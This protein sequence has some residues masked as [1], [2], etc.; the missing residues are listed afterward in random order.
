MEILIQGTIRWKASLALVTF[1]AADCP[2]ADADAWREVH[3]GPL[4]RAIN[5]STPSSQRF[6]IHLYNS[7]NFAYSLHKAHSFSLL[8]NMV[9]T[10]TY[11]FRSTS[12]ARGMLLRKSSCTLADRFVGE[13]PQGIRKE[14]RPLESSARLQQG[15]THQ[16][17]QSLLPAPENS[18]PSSPV[19]LPSLAV[20]RT[21]LMGL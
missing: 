1:F 12:L 9:R 8:I 17:I 14:T 20:W 3:I 10:N 5:H 21:E 7:A 18:G 13:R 19:S 4:A 6:D 11:S 16:L 15:R 2:V